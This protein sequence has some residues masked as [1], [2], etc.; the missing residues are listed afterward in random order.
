VTGVKKGLNNNNKPGGSP[1]A[2]TAV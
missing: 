2:P 1:T